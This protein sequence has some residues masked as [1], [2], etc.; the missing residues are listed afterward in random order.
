MAEKTKWEDGDISY[1]LSIQDSRYDHNYNTV[2]GRIKHAAAPLFGKPVYFN[3]VY[4]DDEGKFKKLV[5]DL[6]ELITDD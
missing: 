1:S 3:D 5:G 2:W 4:I 6:S